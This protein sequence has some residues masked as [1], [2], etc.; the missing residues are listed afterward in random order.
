MPKSQEKSVRETHN[1][2]KIKRRKKS[3]VL[4]EWQRKQRARVRTWYTLV[5]TV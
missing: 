1:M 4:C 3:A 2:T 5:W